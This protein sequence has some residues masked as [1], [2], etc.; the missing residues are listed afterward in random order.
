MW[1]VDLSQYAQGVPASQAAKTG[2][3]PVGDAKLN[4][5][6]AGMYCKCLFYF[7]FFKFILHRGAAGK[8]R[9]KVTHGPKVTV[10]HCR[11]LSDIADKIFQCSM[12][13]PLRKGGRCLG[14]L[15]RYPMFTGCSIWHLSEISTVFCETSAY[16]GVGFFI[17]T[18]V[19]W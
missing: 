15:I 3:N 12:G 13:S 16:V 6:L 5:A 2:S 4:Q 7:I 17:G 19:G 10:L 9:I 18:V 14:F 11:H 1:S 8:G